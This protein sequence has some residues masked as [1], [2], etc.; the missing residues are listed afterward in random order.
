VVGI[1]S[2]FESAIADVTEDVRGVEQRTVAV[3]RRAYRDAQEMSKMLNS[4][5]SEMLLVGNEKTQF[6]C[7]CSFTPN[8][9]GNYNAIHISYGALQHTQEPYISYTN[10][11]TW[12]GGNVTLTQ[13]FIIDDET[14]KEKTEAVD[15]EDD[16][17][18]YLYAQVT[19]ATD[20]NP[21]G[22][23][24]FDLH[25]MAQDS[26]DH[27]L[28]GILSSVF[29]GKRTFNTTNGF[30]AITGGTITTEVIQDASK[31]L[32]IDF[33]NATITARNGGKIR[34]V[35]EVT[36]GDDD[37]PVSELTSIDIGTIDEN[38]INQVTDDL[39]YCS[40]Q[41]DTIDKGNE[42]LASFGT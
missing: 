3:S 40:G 12:E 2:T 33:P 38:Y 25:E 9:E 36:S 32:V 17:P 13:A 5:Q 14:G 20:S 34:G 10:K 21:K 35:I 7:S 19:D 23:I 26:E 8:Y 22:T 37:T 24:T 16:T 29:E 27:L 11:G 4:L 30:S 31:K 18:Y 42:Y 28:V 41:I 6:A 15:L 39:Y 1:L